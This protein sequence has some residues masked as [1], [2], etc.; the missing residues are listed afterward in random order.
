ML[1][2]LCLNLLNIMYL[3]LE[4]H[5]KSILARPRPTVTNVYTGCFS[6]FFTVRVHPDIF[7]ESVAGLYLPRLRHTK[8]QA[9]EDCL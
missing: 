7:G 3:I 6:Y 5:N 4:V 8:T 1:Q 9:A 2:K